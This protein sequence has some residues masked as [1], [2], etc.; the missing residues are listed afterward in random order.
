MKSFA[1]KF[2]LCAVFSCFF[3]GTTLSAN[4]SSKTKPAKKEDL[5]DRVAKKNHMSRAETIKV[6]DSFVAEIN[7]SLK[8]GQAVRIPNLGTFKVFERPA[9]HGKNP[10]TGLNIKVPERKI[11]SYKPSKTAYKNVNIEKSKEH[12]LHPA[13]S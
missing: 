12:S 2:V 11:I 10:R 4:E 5:V 7:V 6:L 1:K 3:L 9:Y 13:H 8:Q